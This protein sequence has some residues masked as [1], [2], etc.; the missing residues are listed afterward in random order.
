M[1][2]RVKKLLLEFAGLLLLACIVIPIGLLFLALPL[3]I[4]IKGVALYVGVGFYESVLIGLI[5]GI[6][7][8]ILYMILNYFGEKNVF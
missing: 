6:Y 5:Y 4:I 7:L 1:N 2:Y 8:I 3:V